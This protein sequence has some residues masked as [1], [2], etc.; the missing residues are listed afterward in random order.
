MKINIK[1]KILILLLIFN[2]DAY[3][4]RKCGTNQKLEYNYS[5]YKDIINKRKKIE[6]K[7]NLST[8][9]N[10]EIKNSI[11]I[12]VVFHIVYNNP[13][14]NIS[15]SQI[16]SQLDILNE[17][18][19]RTNNDAINTPSDFAQIVASMQINFCL[20]KRTPNNTPTTGII[21]TQTN[22]QEFTLYDT[23]IHHDYLGG[24]SAWDTDKYL[25]IWV[26][27]ISGG[28]LGWS[29]YPAGGS[30]YTDGVVIDYRCF[31]LNG[32]SI[33]PY[34]LG[35]TTTHEVGHWLNLF[36]IWGDNT[37]GD[38]YVNDTPI[39]EEANFGCKIHPST[40]CSN[41]GDMFMN[42]MDYTDDYCM[43]SFTIGQRN[44][45]WSSIYN[46]R[47]GLLTSNGCEEIN[48]STNNNVSIIDILHPNDTMI[49]ECS[50]PI[51]PKILIKNLSSETI[52]YATIKYRINSSA[53]KYQLWSGNL[54]QGE[55]EEVYLSGINIEGTNHIIHVECL[56]P[57]GNYDIDPTD[58]HM[59]KIFTTNG[60]NSI[61][62]NLITDNYANETS[63]KLLNNQDEILD[64]S[65]VLT[66]NTEYTHN[67][68]LD[69]GCYKLII[70]DSQGDG[71]CCSYGSGS[72]IITKEL[73]NQTISTLGTFTYTDTIL[74]CVT[75]LLDKDLHHNKFEVYPNP[76]SGKITIKSDY[77]QHENPIIAKIYNSQGILIRSLSIKNNKYIN[78][79]TLEDGIYILRIL[80][81]GRIYNKKIIINTN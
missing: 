10:N 13:T 22:T 3:T 53:Y 12:P 48:P 68:C 26:T 73:N 16:M 9:P 42:F 65:G 28:I 38:D 17:D 23:T 35:R 4:Q 57:N 59:T 79:N 15:D 44:R 18:F 7:I 14:Q 25:N 56:M 47:S 72:L 62:I 32:T 60:G 78:L 24:S 33:H 29:Q 45:V 19:N 40:S 43:N 41:N 21:R 36:H 66:N 46:Y 27:N 31:G 11:T 39:Q 61:N 20:A 52:Y 51:Y 75:A 63:W 69:D 77:F 67:Y 80:D 71:I 2:I 81:K 5:I 70:N 30:Q 34:N 64:T 6:K 76:S 37:C 8:S 54:A 49:E 74:F 55:S 1:Y 58:N 50:N